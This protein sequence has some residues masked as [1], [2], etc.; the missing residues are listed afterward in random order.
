VHTLR[1]GGD[2]PRQAI[3]AGEEGRRMTDTH[4]AARAAQDATSG[5][6]RRQHVHL[7]ELIDEMMAS[8]R[9]AANRDLFTADERADAES[10]LASIMARV[11]AEALTVSDRR[12]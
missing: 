11:H 1:P 5:R 3:D 4:A 9:A 2:P 6:E 10:Q 8:L 7:R 12:A